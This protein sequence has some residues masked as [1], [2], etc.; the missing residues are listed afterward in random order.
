MA[1]SHPILVMPTV[2]FEPPARIPADRNDARP[3][4]GEGASTLTVRAE[5]GGALADVCDEA[6]AP[7]PFSC[8]SANCGTCR[9]EVLE[10]ASELT[11]P[12]DEE[13]DV[14]EIFASPPTHRLA[15]CAKMKSGLAVL[16]IRP[17]DDDE[18]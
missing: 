13:L 9:I 5:A 15:C 17:V 1:K 16:R 14:L 6:S 8:R 7:I 3:P 10:G 2:I 11:A 18:L 12:E 4:P